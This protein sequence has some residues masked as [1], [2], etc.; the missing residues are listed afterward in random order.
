MARGSN[1]ISKEEKQREKITM[2]ISK[3][4]PFGQEKYEN[5]VVAFW[6][7]ERRF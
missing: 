7:F 3:F 6:N 2:K 5:H 1:Q 4:L